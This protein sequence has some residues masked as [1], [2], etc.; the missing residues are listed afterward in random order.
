MRT[1]PIRHV[2]DVWT[3][4]VDKHTVEGELPVQ[5]CNYTDAYKKDRVRPGPDLMKATATPEEISRNRLKVGDSVFTKDSEDPRD[6]GI[7]A[8]VDEEADDFVCGYHLAIARPHAETHPRFLNWSL[9]S[10][11][12][13]EHF[14]NHAA[15]ISRYGIGLSDLRSA[16]I[17]LVANHEQR[18]IADFLD[19]RVSR[20]DRIIT[21]R[22]EQLSQLSESA[23]RR[24]YDAVRGAN[25]STDFRES[26]LPWLGSIPASWPVLSV[27]SQFS[28]ELGKMLDDKRQTGAHALPYLRNTNVQWDSI[29]VNDLKTMDIPLT[30]YPRY[31]VKPGDLLICEGGQPGRSA[32]WNGDISPLGFQK[33]LHRA[34]SRGRSLPSWLLECL[35]VAANLDVFASGSGQTTIAHLTNEQL[36][37]Q[38]F[39]F[40]DPAVQED[41]LSRLAAHRHR[42]ASTI[43]ALHRSIDLLTECKSSLIS[44]A[45]TGELDVTTAGSN[46]PG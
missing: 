7:S 37:Q 1:I 33:A 36:R 38:R 43:S 44:A 29:S 25:T 46:I 39:P 6:I 4:S 17:P 45:V 16:P 11:P 20:V 31:T 34:R 21:A 32:I 23:A 5:L 14:G 40:P 35:R 28:V 19:D 15:G 8:F 27:G 24:S 42:I 22:R 26:G 13:L 9:R 41:L 3:S 12:V 2:A 18:R 10:R 30:E